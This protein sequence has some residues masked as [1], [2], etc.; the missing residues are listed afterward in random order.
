MVSILKVILILITLDFSS[1]LL[2]ITE[3]S[4]D[5]FYDKELATVE[6]N[7]NAYII[8]MMYSN[9]GS[10][11]ASRF[12]EIMLQYLGKFWEKTRFAPSSIFF[13]KNFS[14][15]TDYFINL[16]KN[17]ISF[18]EYF[19]GSGKSINDFGNEHYCIKNNNSNINKE[20]Y[21]FLLHLDN[22]SNAI[23]NYED[24]DLFVFINKYTLYIGICLPINCSG[25]LYQ[26][27]NEKQFLDFMQNSLSCNNFSINNHTNMAEKYDGEISNVG[28]CIKWT[29]YIL[30]LIKLIISILKSSC[31]MKGYERCFLENFDKNEKIINEEE[32]NKIKINE[33]KI[34]ND[35]NNNINNDVKDAYFEYIYGISLKEEENL[36]NPFH[37]YQDNFPLIL[38]LMKI[39][40][41]IDNIKLL[42]FSISNK[43]Y[44]SCKIKRIYFLKFFVMLMSVT[45]K[46]FIN[47][48]ELPTK[49]FLIGEAYKR[50][51]FFLIKICVFSSSFWIILDAVTT[52]FKL[53]SYIKKKIGSSSDNKLSFT[54]Y[55]QFILLII[56]KAIL[57]I[58]CYFTLYIYGKNIIYTLSD[59]H[60]IGPFILYDKMIEQS[61]YA[62]RDDNIYTETKKTNRIFK[63]LI[64]LWIN[65]IDYFTEETNITK[66]KIEGNGKP[67]FDPNTSNITNITYYE[68]D[69][70]RY[71]IPSPFLTNAELFI[72]IY[73]NEFVLL[74][75]MMIITYLS[76]KIRYKLFDISIFFVNIILY[77]I[78]AFNWT[79]YN[80]NNDRYTLL[81][82]LG[83]NYSEKYTH[84]FINFY[85]FGFIIGIMLFYHYENDY[86]KNYRINDNVI[87]NNSIGSNSDSFSSQN[88]DSVYLPFNIFKVIITFLNNFNINLKR[89]IL[90]LSLIF[91]FIISESFS[92]I[93]EYYKDGEQE[94]NNEIKGYKYTDEIFKL[95]IPSL[96]DNFIKF[97]FL[98]EKNLC[99]IFFFVFLLMVIVYPSN[100]IFIKFCSLNFFIL[101]DRINFSFYCSFSFFV[102][103]AFCVFYLD[104]RLKYTSVILNS[105]GI[106]IL[107]IIINILIVSTIELPFRILIK[108]FMN[109]NTKENFKMNFTSGGLL[110]QSQRST[111]SK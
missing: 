103:M 96:D 76:Y 68:Y 81:Y 16:D 13:S 49:S 52:G 42:L 25:I 48:I 63:S 21:L 44:N 17:N 40:D 31:M 5:F 110:S 77:I 41:L 60:H 38:K 4:Y 106:F 97:I 6:S 95:K 7:L 74:I 29:F 83:Q 8:R 62:L 80:I 67:Y 53:M 14:I 65:Y 9:K 66:I 12:I 27:F 2:N 108:S 99:C 36:Y 100:S 75:L 45:L 26:L 72:N 50:R 105:V 24:K 19:E 86:K 30:V 91:I 94:K 54:S 23:T 15:C 61:K 3:Y 34:N 88:H 57:F 43:Y 71:K 79:K 32:E 39:I 104:F 58:V 35:V 22:H 64:P 78:P 51:F 69:L 59:P 98:Y 107:I 33:K 111:L 90:W 28:L 101:F 84:Y 70:T 92:F 56:P 102:N 82:V 109:K 1:S 11:S 47:Q 37:D 46:L 20:Y 10:D 89:I 93:Q 73:F 55:I 85:Y 87:N 18:Y